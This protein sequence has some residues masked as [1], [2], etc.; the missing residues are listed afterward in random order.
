MRE[1]V[2]DAR[3]NIPSAPD[4]V[5]LERARLVTEGARAFAHE[6]TPIRSARTFDH[7]LSRMTLDLTT[8][9]IFAGNTSSRPRGWMLLPEY[10]FSVPAQALIENPRLEGFLDGDAVPEELRRFWADRAFGGAA[11]WGHLAVDNR[12]LLASGLEDVIAE[13]EREAHDPDPARAAY[14]RACSIACR[15]VIKWAH[16]YAQAAEHLAEETGDPLR[17]EA[18]KRIAAACQRVPARPARNL[19][20]AL[21]SLVLVHLAI[22]IEGHGYSVSP[23]RLDQL[24]IPYY[25]G[26][27][28]AVD[29]LAA[30]FL[31]LTAN[32]LWGSHSK[33]QPNTV[34][35]S[36]NHGRDQSNPL[37]LAA[38][39]ACELARAPDPAL[40]LRWHRG[41]PDA[42]KNKAVELLLSGLSFPLLIGDPQTAAGL[43]AG[44]IQPDD[45]A[46][47]CVIGCNELGVPARLIWDAVEFSDIAALNSVLEQP[48][49]DTARSVDDLL[50][51]MEAFMEHTL[52]EHIERHQ[53]Y[54]R[55]MADRV[56]TPFTTALMHGGPANGVDLL[57]RL[58]YP[59]LNVRSSG[60]VNLVNALSAI[61][62]VVFQA[63]EA[64]LS[65]LRAALHD[66]F[67]GAQALREK[68]LAAP[69][70]GR[71]D[72]RADRWAVAW[73]ERRRAVLSRLEQ[74]E[75]CPPLMMEMVVRSLHH[76][77]G[78]Q[79]G[80]T[81]DGRR[82]GEALADS[83]GP[84]A[85]TAT[86]PPTA[87]LNSIRKMD[88]AACWP[89][90]YNL[91]LT[92]PAGPLTGPAVA[93]KIVALIDAFFD[94]GG[95]ELQINCLN[96][97]TL[98]QAK[99][100]P[101]AYPDLLVRVA[102]FN[103]LFAKLSGVEQDEL[104]RRAEAAERVS[105]TGPGRP[106]RRS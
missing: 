65:G 102:G 91:N 32:S 6:P 29:L 8:N 105:G 43:R 71:D 88:A 60:F 14:R 87:V 22:H 9:P 48:D 57:Q 26:E 1:L 83:I 50:A 10:S 36:D 55:R 64:T 76:L 12:R 59:Q 39:Q 45:A 73:A 106:G 17:A 3:R 99:L 97:A 75:G 56:P 25:H 18:L 69:K 13:A 2:L 98:H 86:A 28:D 74:R 38:L 80:A 19:F 61:D 7:I 16:R 52:A 4:T 72:D 21:Q 47:Y 34:G 24:L 54:T 44:G 66:N 78:L 30:F 68:L 70:W 92:L 5:C 84:S 23:G 31:K 85:G 90:G 79:L 82:A 94:N 49:I 63:R 89:G 33:T 103:A 96:A 95:Q 77:E 93:A 40:F 37:T 100:H 35:G 46:N 27:H 81:P 41:L 62:A 20:E 58:P 67:L 53:K 15:A 42:L 51:R 104:I 11:G 101:E